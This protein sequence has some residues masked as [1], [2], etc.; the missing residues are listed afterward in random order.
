V[1]FCAKPQITRSS[2][3][4]EFAEASAIDAQSRPCVNVSTKVASTNLAQNFF[5]AVPKLLLA[6]AD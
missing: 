6:P 4:S 3:N 5:V 2:T 1:F